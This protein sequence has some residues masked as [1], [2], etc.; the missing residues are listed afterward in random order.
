MNLDEKFFLNSFMDS[1]FTLASD[2]VRNVRITIASVVIKH[3]K[4]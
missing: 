2:P 4:R 1:M 3:I